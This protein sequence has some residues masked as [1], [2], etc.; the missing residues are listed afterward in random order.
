MSYRA[1]LPSSLGDRNVP[2]FS[3]IE[4]VV[5][6]GVTVVIVIAMAT[7]FDRSNR[8]TK[9]EN[10]VTE[11][12]QN[13]RYAIYHAAR[14][15]RM[16]GAGGLPSNPDLAAGLSTNRQ[17]PVSLNLGSSSY[18][19]TGFLLNNVGAGG[20]DVAIGGTHYV[21]NGT[22]AIH[23]RG[24]LDGAIYD[25]GGGNW[26]PTGGGS[27]T[28]GTLTIV[29]C[30]KYLDPL[31]PPKLVA[32]AGFAA[33]DM[34]YFLNL[35]ATW[36]D[37]MFVMKDASGL[38]GVGLVH[39]APVPTTAGGLTSAQ[40]TLDMTNAYVQSLNPGGAFPAALTNPIRGG[41]LDDR[42]FFVDNGTAAGATCTAAK[43]NLVP[44]PCHPV[45]SVADWQS[46]DSTTAPF[47]TATVTQVA[48]DIEDMQVAYGIDFFN[49]QSNVGTFASPAPIVGSNNFPSDGSI[50]ILDQTVFN[51]IAAG[52]TTNVDPLEDASAKDK[53][54]WIGNTDAELGTGGAY[55][56]AFNETFDL[57]RLR[58]IEI[59]FL[60]KSA[61]PD[62]KFAGEGATGW[63]L[64]DS[65][66]A[67]VS[68]QDG[69]PYHRRSQTMRIDLRNLQFH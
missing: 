8:L 20:T 35:P 21:R 53:D 32:C 24:I 10:N 25:L 22:D 18:G 2:G 40:L 28:G 30:S 15:I 64:M 48:E 14:D 68:A 11:A 38:I 29:N 7:L 62:P 42:V 57:S 54:E 4:L 19:T 36:S 55:T 5:S 1:P 33:N 3:V 34:S 67:T 45:F 66:A 51:S 69:F 41:F 26:A 61:Q 6:L 16:A 43:A 13:V 37:R 65:Q 52:T 17:F 63:K 46:G 58:A 44:G 31:S 59:S 47:S 9:V 27:V 49:V 50:S 39:V 12:Q 23:I 56:S 60:A